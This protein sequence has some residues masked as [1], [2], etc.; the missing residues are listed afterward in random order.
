VSLE[1]GSSSVKVACPIT[2]LAAWPVRKSAE[3]TAAAERKKTQIHFM[4][5]VVDTFKWPVDHQL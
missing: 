5:N 1:L 3:K 4:G 2:A